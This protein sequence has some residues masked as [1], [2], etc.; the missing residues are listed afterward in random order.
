M[1]QDPRD[2]VREPAEELARVVAEVG[3]GVLARG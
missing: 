2:G 1:E 3:W